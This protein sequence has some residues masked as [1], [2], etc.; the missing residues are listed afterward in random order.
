MRNKV[1]NPSLIEVASS[2][3]RWSYY[4]YSK[5]ALMKPGIELKIDVRAKVDIQKVRAW[6]L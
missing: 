2:S 1:E 4:N 6:L 5:N 3:T